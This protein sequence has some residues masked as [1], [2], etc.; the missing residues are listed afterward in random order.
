MEK[1][2]SPKKLRL[3]RETLRSLQDRQFATIGAGNSQYSWCFCN[4]SEPCFIPTECFCYT[5]P[6]D[7]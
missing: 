2:R 7:C 1:K 5:G 6:P 4:S 3:N